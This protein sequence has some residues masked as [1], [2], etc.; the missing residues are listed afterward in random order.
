MLSKTQ[1][2]KYIEKILSILPIL[3]MTGFLSVFHPTIAKVNGQGIVDGTVKGVTDTLYKKRFRGGAPALEKFL[4]KN[5]HYP[6]GAYRVSATGLVTAQF[7]LLPDGSIK[8]IKLMNGTQKDLGKE[9]ERLIRILPKFDAAPSGKV[10]T[11][12]LTFLFQLVDE[13]GKYVSPE[14]SKVEADIFV[15]GYPPIHKLH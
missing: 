8:D 4:S 3:A 7:N 15:T 2:L 14:L 10:D 11:A 12:V 1:S 13:Q 6:P 9:V 5:I